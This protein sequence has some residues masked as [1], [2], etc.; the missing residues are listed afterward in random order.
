M[1]RT[2]PVVDCGIHIIPSLFACKTHWFK[3]PKTLRDDIW[4]AWNANNMDAHVVAKQAAMDW[5]AEN[6]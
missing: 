3:L 1:L 6:L 4:T 5:Y 2:C